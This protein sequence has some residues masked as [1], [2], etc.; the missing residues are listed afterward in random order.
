MYPTELRQRRKGCHLSLREVEQRTASLAEFLNDRRYSVSR[1]WLS[2]VE[3][4]GTSPPLHK[5]C[6][7]LI[8][9]RLPLGS[10]PRLCGILEADI[11][12]YQLG[13]PLRVSSPFQIEKH[14]DYDG[15]ER[16]LRLPEFD[17]GFDRNFGAMDEYMVVGQGVAEL[18][19]LTAYDN[20]YFQYAFIGTQDTRM[21]PLIP[22][23]SFIQID[24]RQRQVA[25]GSLWPEELRPLFAVKKENRYFAGWLESNHPGLTILA[26]PLSGDRS[27]QI[28]NPDDIEIIGRI[29]GVIMNLES[30]TQTEAARPHI[31]SRKRETNPEITIANGDSEKSESDF[32]SRH[33]DARRFPPL[34]NQELIKQVVKSWGMDPLL[35]WQHLDHFD[36]RFTY[37]GLQ[38]RMAYPRLLPGAWLRIDERKKQIAHGPWLNNYQR[39]FYVVNTPEGQICAWVER[40]GDDLILVPYPGSSGERRSF[41]QGKEAQVLGRVIWAATRLVDIAG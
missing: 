1:T 7:L 31:S 25:G 30:K 39:P 12:K 38:D 10:L 3:R 37:I 17:A 35:L 26:H 22:V 40:D 20:G 29:T 9:Y 32:N 2:E 19:Q 36:W 24:S 34:E 4:G 8:V 18:S 14:L 16:W 11:I 28:K 27:F 41:R 15:G 33:L 5:L 6:A 13:A 21:A 23:G